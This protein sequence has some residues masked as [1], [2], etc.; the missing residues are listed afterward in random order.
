[1]KRSRFSSK[2]LNP[3]YPGWYF[4]VDYLVDFHDERY[5]RAW[6]HAQLIHVEG[7]IWHPIVRAAALGMLGRRAEAIPHIDE[8]RRLKPEFAERP[9]DYIKRLLVLPEHVDMIW[10]GLLEAGIQDRLPQH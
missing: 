8:L 6:T 1:M 3:S 9:R 10:H 5:E 7:M 2:K 4:F